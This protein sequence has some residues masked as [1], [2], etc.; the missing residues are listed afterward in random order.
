MSALAVTI[1]AQTRVKIMRRVPAAAFYPRPK[2]D[3]AVMRLEPLPAEERAIK[4]DELADFVTL[5][6]AGFKQPRKTLANSLAD[7][8]G[9]PKPE[10][11]QRLVAAAVDPSKRPEALALEDWVRLFRAT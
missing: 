2:V 6:Q 10:A 3:S 11:I 8:L 5:V 9:I 7:G 1:Q 4:R